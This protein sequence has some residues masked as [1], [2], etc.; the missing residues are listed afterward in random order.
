MHVAGQYTTEKES[1]MICPTCRAEQTWSAECRR[2]KSDLSDL[3]EVWRAGR[4]ARIACLSALRAG[5]FD[6]ALRNARRYAAIYPGDAAARLLAICYLL[7]G[8]WP[9]ALSASH[10]P[11][12]WG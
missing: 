9:E 7:R 1:T 8:D 11:T 12:E 5:S 3:H 10:R 2:C 4:Q 6:R